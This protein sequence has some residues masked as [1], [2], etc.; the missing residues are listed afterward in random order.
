METS[1]V[2]LLFQKDNPTKEVL[3]CW[4]P[5]KKTSVNKFREILTRMERHDVLEI[6]DGDK[7]P[8]ENLIKK[9]YLALPATGNLLYLIYT[10]INIFR[11]CT[12]RVTPCTVILLLSISLA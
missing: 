12:N 6:L 1:H 9:A 5:H 2:W 3:K 10:S 7:Q 4:V 8:G 11:I